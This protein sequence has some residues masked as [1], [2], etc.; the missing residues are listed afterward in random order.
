MGKHDANYTALVECRDANEVSALLG[1]LTTRELWKLLDLM[2][3]EQADGRKGMIRQLT[4][5]AATWPANRQ[6]ATVTPVIASVPVIRSVDPDSREYTRDYTN[7]YTV[8][9][10]GTEGALE[11]ADGRNV[12][13]AWYDGYHDAAAGRDKWTYRTWR[14]NGCDANCGY[15]CDGPCIADRVHALKGAG[16]HVRTDPYGEDAT[17]VELS[18]VAMDDDPMGQATTWQRSNYRRLMADYPD[19]LTR[20][21]YW[22]SANVRDLSD[23][24]VSVL[25]GLATEYPLYDESDVSELESDDVWEAFAAY[26]HADLRRS[27]TSA[28]RELWDLLPFDAL[29]TAFYGGMHEADYSP[30]HDGRDIR[31]D[32]EVTTLCARQAIVDVLRMERPQAMTI[33]RGMVADARTWH[34]KARTV[35]PRYRSYAQDCL[36]VVAF[37]RRALTGMVAA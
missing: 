3:I 34:E 27:L 9:L 33:A 19:V 37:V 32:D 20:D 30:E 23:E 13:H 22:L 21:Y 14:R 5:E 8:G 31:W 4:D 12:S 11:A 7:G 1:S 25:C 16:F 2:H 28:E 29:R 10:R 18:S 35:N 17:T 15:A 36:D 24:L 26:L 6:A